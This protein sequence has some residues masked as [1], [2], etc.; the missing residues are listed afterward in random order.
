MVSELGSSA[1]LEGGAGSIPAGGSF[2]LFENCQVSVRV[3]FRKKVIGERT[4]AMSGTR[5]IPERF[6]AVPGFPTKS[7]SGKP[8]GGPQ[9]VMVVSM[10]VSYSYTTQAFC[11]SRRRRGFDPRLRQF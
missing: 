8:A 4:G 9:S 1:S 7:V 10:I 5:K 2:S 11:Q 3:Q 6:S